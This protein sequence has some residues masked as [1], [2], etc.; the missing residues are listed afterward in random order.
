MAPAARLSELL[1][2]AKLTPLA[3]IGPDPEISG[4]ALDSR[5][6]EPGDLFFAIQGYRDDG[7]R[8]SEGSRH[9]R[10]IHLCG[11]RIDSVRHAH[12]LLE[13]HATGR[14]RRRDRDRV[15]QEPPDRSHHRMVVYGDG[16]RLP[17]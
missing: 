13:Y 14:R 11:D 16:V 9:S 2:G 6:I 5:R 10:E 3:P 1:R 12:A 7:E 15:V 4:A 8:F 17:Y